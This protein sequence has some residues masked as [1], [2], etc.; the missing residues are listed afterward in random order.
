VNEDKVFIRIGEDAKEQPFIMAILADGMGGLQAGDL[1]SEIALESIKEWW[2]DRVIHIIYEKNIFEIIENELRDKFNEINQSLLNL[3]KKNGI[4]LGTTLSVLFMYKGKY[5]IQ[6]VGDSRIYR[7]CSFVQDNSEDH[8]EQNIKSRHMMTQLTEDHSWVGMQM[9]NGY[10]SAEEARIHPKRNVLLQCIGV[11]KLLFPFSQVG[12]YEM[13]DLF[14]LCSDGF[15][16]MF[17]DKKIVE[18]IT[19]SMNYEDLNLNTLSD[20]LVDIAIEAGATDNISLAIIRQ[21]AK[22]ETRW[23]KIISVFKSLQRR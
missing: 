17:S 15:H 16:S 18:L 2:N 13:D 3:Y 6:H 11:N 1:A 10:F 12:Y 20:H 8:F 19:T 21:G 14:L 9:K 7:I 4:E 5:V 23:K 22:V